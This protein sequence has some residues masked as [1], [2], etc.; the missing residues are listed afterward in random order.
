MNAVFVAVISLLVVVVATGSWTPPSECVFPFTYAG[1][2]YSDC[3]HG[4]AVTNRHGGSVPWCST[5]PDGD[6]GGGDMWLKCTTVEA[7]TYG[8]YPNINT[9]GQNRI[10][11]MTKKASWGDCAS[12][13][14]SNSECKFWTWAKESAGKWANECY[15]MR[16]YS[17][18]NSDSNTITGPKGCA[19]ALVNCGPKR[20]KAK[21]CAECTQNIQTGWEMCKGD[22]RFRHAKCA[23]AEDAPA[24]VKGCK[25]PSDSKAK[26]YRG[27]IATTRTGK[28]CQAWAEQSPHTHDMFTRSSLRQYWSDLGESASQASNYCRNPDNSRTAWCYTVDKSDRWQFCDIPKCTSQSRR[29]GFVQCGNGDFARRCGSCGSCLDQDKG[30]ECYLGVDEAVEWTGYGGYICVPFEEGDLRNYD[31]WT[32]TSK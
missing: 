7:C 25:E 8:V 5:N 11:S 3:V 1:I 15:L 29:P 9:Q 27:H 32:W 10:G 13:C 24:L 31:N 2:T 18:M 4:V 26:R 6:Y 17:Y 19:P 21:S 30:Q 22:C 12:A 28:P 16:S 23:L 20:G 14:S